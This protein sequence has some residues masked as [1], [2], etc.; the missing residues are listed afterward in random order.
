MEVLAS[1]NR[2]SAITFL[3]FYFSSKMAPDHTFNLTGPAHHN[4]DGSFVTHLIF[5]TFLLLFTIPI[6]V[7]GVTICDRLHFYRWF[8]VLFKKL[9]HMLQGVWGLY[10]LA[11]ECHRLQK[12]ACRLQTTVP[13][14][15]QQLVQT[16]PSSDKHVFASTTRP[17]LIRHAEESP[18]L[19]SLTSQEILAPQWD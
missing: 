11:R 9:Y 14:P 15:S 7:Q 12:P 3:S 1:T 8:G 10:Q 19:A 4:S 5:T 18:L 13:R 17:I 2:M 16:S 6:W